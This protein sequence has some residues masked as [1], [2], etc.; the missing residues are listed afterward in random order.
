[1]IMLIYD[2]Y[3]ILSMLQ[4]RGKIAVLQDGLIQIQFDTQNVIYTLKLY[5]SVPSMQH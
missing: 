3:V 1:M 4:L 2:K 5:L